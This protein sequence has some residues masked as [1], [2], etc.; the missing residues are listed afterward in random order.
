MLLSELRLSSDKHKKEAPQ[1]E[2]GT[3]RALE[4]SM[5]SLMST[6]DELNKALS[7]YNKYIQ[8]KQKYDMTYNT[9]LQKRVNIIKTPKLLLNSNNLNLSKLK[10][11]YGKQRAKLRCHWM[12]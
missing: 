9:L 7:T 8:E 12:I 4:K 1:L 3:R 2:L 11:N 6:V 10:M 5:R